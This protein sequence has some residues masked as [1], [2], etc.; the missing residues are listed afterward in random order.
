M[1]VTV[2]WQRKKYNANIVS[3]WMEVN[4]ECLLLKSKSKQ[5]EFYFKIWSI[6]TWLYIKMLKQILQ[7]KWLKKWIFS[8]WIQT[9]LS[10]YSISNR[11]QHKWI[12]IQQSQ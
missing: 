11:S 8:H 10:S 1:I 7:N 6:L 4:I 3:G 12:K 9:E 2:E 5:A